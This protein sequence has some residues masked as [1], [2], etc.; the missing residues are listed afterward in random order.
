MK[1]PTRFVLEVETLGRGFRVTSPTCGITE[2]DVEGLSLESAL[3]TAL[4]DID[5][6]LLAKEIDEKAQSA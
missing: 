3:A 1:R 6:I 5:A 4:I 2:L